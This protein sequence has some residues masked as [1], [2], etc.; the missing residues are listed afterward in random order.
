M[1]AE[2]KCIRV[3][4]KCGWTASTMLERETTRSTPEQ[5]R[6]Q[7]TLRIHCWDEFLSRYSGLTPEISAIL[8]DAWNEGFKHGWLHYQIRKEPLS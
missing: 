2:M 3:M 4:S 1:S 7:N 6:N 8:K 5:M